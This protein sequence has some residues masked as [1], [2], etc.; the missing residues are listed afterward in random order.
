MKTTKL[1]TLFIFISNIVFS[2]EKPEVL[3]SLFKTMSQ[4]GQFY[5]NVLIAAQNEVVFSKCYGY[6][7][8]QKQEL[9]NEQSLFNVGSVSKAFT[10]IA[11]LQL[12]EKEKLK[13]SDK[14]IKYLPGFAYPEITIHHLLIHAG[15]LPADYDLLKNSN[16]W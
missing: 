16:S 9:L 1:F 2:K 6:A 5:G 3:D 15:G 7:D 8:R 14:V 10:A 13:L 4:R 12:A 11:I